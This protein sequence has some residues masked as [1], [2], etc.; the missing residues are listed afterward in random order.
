MLNKQILLGEIKLIEDE[1]Q[2]IQRRLEY[3]TRQLEKQEDLSIPQY[4]YYNP[5]VTVYS[6][7]LPNDLVTYCNS[8][9]N[10]DETK[11]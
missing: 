2:L 3:M 1:L 4:P 6:C 10:T 11:T 7:P 5:V 8:E 9:V